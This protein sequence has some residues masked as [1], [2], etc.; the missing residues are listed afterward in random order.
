[1]EIDGIEFVW[2]GH[3]AFK[4]KAEGLVLYIDPFEISGN[5]KADIILITHD[6]YDHCSEK[7]LQKIIKD[8]T[9]IVCTKTTALKLKTKTITIEPNQEKNV[10]GIGIKAV[11]AYNC[12]KQFHPKGNGIGFILNIVGKRIYHA[13]DTDLIPEMQNISKIDIALLP[14]GGKYTMNA[15][16]AAEAAE[17]IKPKVAIP[18]H[19][20]SIVGSQ[21]D[22]QTFKE[23]YSGRTLIL[24]KNQ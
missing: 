24:N 3:S 17:I 19:Y 15:E 18:M 1:M 6:H 23:L 10:F 2:L 8:K 20:G 12:G 13:G 5:E 22:A 21:K 11:P 4:I 7:D 16:E 9:Q 14:V